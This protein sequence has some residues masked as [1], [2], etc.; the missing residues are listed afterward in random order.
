VIRAAP[1]RQQA[2][3]GAISEAWMAAFVRWMDRAAAKKCVDGYQDFCG[4]PHPGRRAILM[5]IKRD[6]TIMPYR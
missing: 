2:S 4:V 3:A 1:P 5:G 6:G